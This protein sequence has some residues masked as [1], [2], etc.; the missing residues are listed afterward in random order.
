MDSVP[1]YDADIPCGSVCLSSSCYVC[2]KASCKCTWDGGRKCKKHLDPSHQCETPA[3]SFR[4]RTWAFPR[5]GYCGY[6][7]SEQAAEDHFLSFL[8]VS[9]CT[10]TPSFK[11][12]NTSQEKNYISSRCSLSPQIQFL[13]M[14]KEEMISLCNCP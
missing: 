13:I 8:S 11:C 2:R 3:Q 7:G 10:H 5:L 12:I 6:L 4:I 1:T 14:E 9:L